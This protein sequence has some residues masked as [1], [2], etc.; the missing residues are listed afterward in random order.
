MIRDAYIRY[1]EIASSVP[2]YEQLSKEE[3][4]N[5]YIYYSDLWEETFK[6]CKPYID[7]L[8]LPEDEEHPIDTYTLLE[9]AEVPFD[10]QEEL[11]GYETPKSQ[12]F[13]VVMIKWW[14]KIYEMMKQSL[15]LK[16]PEDE[17]VNWL[18]D[19]VDIACRYR[20]WLD[21]DSDVYGKKEAV[22]IVMSRCCFSTRGREY[23]HFN[24]D[25]RK[26]NVLL[27]SIDSMVEDNGDSALSYTGAVSVNNPL[28]GASELVTRFL[29]EGKPIEALILDGIAYQDSFK[30]AKSSHKEIHINFN[31]KTDEE[32][33][34]EVKVYDYDYTYDDKK[35]VK[36]LNRVDENF[37]LNYFCHA[38]DISVEVGEDILRKLN[39]MNNTKLYKI[40]K[41]TKI[42]IAQ[43][44]ELLSYLQ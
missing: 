25:K 36:H 33:E 16:L 35:L 30:E 20:A 2:G 37:I 29:A 5:T 13:A 34:E 42:Q 22:D 32:E 19:S 39:S 6:K 44:P 24:K 7:A 41:K 3:A 38:Y 17:Y 15:S 14:Y 11:K 12:Y 1:K 28:R 4:I 40:I 9:M 10:L 23:Q 26:A 21:P 43:S 18:E 27:Y 31:D 8:G